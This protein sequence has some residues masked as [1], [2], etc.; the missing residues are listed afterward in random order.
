[1]TNMRR[2]LAALAL[3]GA[4]LTT[5]GTAHAA[6]PGDKG[7]QTSSTAVSTSGDNLLRRTTNALSPLT[8]LLPVNFNDLGH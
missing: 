1:M 4:A 5:T 3:A 6:D 8:S 7:D 2:T